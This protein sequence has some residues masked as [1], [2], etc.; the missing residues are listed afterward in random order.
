MFNRNY[1]SSLF[2]PVLGMQPQTSVS[3]QRNINW[4]Y[5]IAFTSTAHT[6]SI[7]VPRNI[8]FVTWGLETDKVYFNQQFFSALSFKLIVLHPFGAKSLED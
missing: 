2:F 3:M 7:T 1:S 4:K 6:G 8:I 5:I